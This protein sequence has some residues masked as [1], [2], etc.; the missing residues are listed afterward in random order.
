MASAGDSCA[1]S[2]SPRSGTWA[3]ASGRWSSGCRRRRST[4]PKLWPPKKGVSSTHCPTSPRPLPTSSAP[5]CSGPASAA[6]TRISNSSCTSSSPTCA[7]SA[8][9]LRSCTTP[10]R[11]SCPSCPAH[12]GRS[13]GS[14]SAWEPS[15]RPRWRPTGTAWTPALPV[16]SLTVSS[17]GRPSSEIPAPAPVPPSPLEP[18]QSPA[19]PP[20]PRGP[21]LGI[22]QPSAFLAGGQG[23]RLRRCAMGVPPSSAVH[24]ERAAREQT[25]FGDENLVALTSSLF[26]GGLETTSNTIQF[27]LLVLGNFPD[28]QARVQGELDKAVGRARPPAMEDRLR[29]P[30]T[31]AVLHELQRYLDLVPMSLPH[32]TIRPTAFRG[33][34]IPQGTTIIPLLASG[35]FDPVSWET[36]ED[37]NPGHFLDENGA[38]R[39][40]D[41]AMPFSAGKRMCPGEG[42][43]KVEIFLFITTLL[44]NFTLQLLTDPGAIDLASLR[45]AFRGSGLAYKL[46]AVP[47]PA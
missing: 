45:R 28:V 39:K 18:G 9:S 42:L 25:E 14:I 47:R 13:S 5:W 27:S 1:V 15:S 29:L 41:A 7:T 22:R 17:C 21:G 43:A 34:F 35:H 40:R 4:S 6:T 16:T 12:T 33:Y 46:R 26:I 11:G 19:I 8:P 31:N 23:G 2:P 38:F 32:T 30:Y 44:Q 10:S 3:W 37:F 20:S 24:Q 36:P